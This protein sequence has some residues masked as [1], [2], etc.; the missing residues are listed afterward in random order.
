M[1]VLARA[2]EPHD[3]GMIEQAVTAAR[4]GIGSAPA[5]IEGHELL[6]QSLGLLGRWKEAAS[7]FSTCIELAPRTARHHVQLSDALVES[8]DP[9]AALRVVDQMNQEF[10]RSVD[11]G[12]VR[13]RALAAFGRIDEARALLAQCRQAMPNH[14]DLPRTE[15]AMGGRP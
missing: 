13:A 6:G 15:M 7:S 4:S 3:L 2:R 10:G 5:A 14:P 9:M 12:L 1:L 11:A 8:G